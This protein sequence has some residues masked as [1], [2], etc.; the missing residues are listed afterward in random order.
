MYGNFSQI[1]QIINKPV[2]YLSYLQYRN[3][4]DHPI[5]F[6]AGYAKS[7]TTWLANMFSS[8]PG[9]HRV[10]PSHITNENHDINTKTFQE[11]RRQLAVICLHSPWTQENSHILEKNNQKYIVLYRDLRDTAVS[12]YFY[13]KNVNKKHSLHSTIKN[14][15]I[16]RGVEYYIEY[17]LQH[18]VNW[19]RS[20]RMNRHKD[21]ST[22]VR[23]EDLLNDTYIE[24]K[25]LLDFFS[26]NLPVAYIRKIVDKNSF[27]KMT[28]R[29]PGEEDNSSHLR[30]GIIGD[31]KN[32]LTKK[33]KEDFKRIAGDLL[34]E[35][36][37]EKDL[38]W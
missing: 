5:I 29:D 35:L 24:F 12:W 2:T 7:G 4:Y 6:I 26:I 23:Y 38:K 16:N 17:I 3:R 11:I 13:I 36:G 18:N 37:Y 10:F 34:I 31:W 14:L 19:I 22:E 28:K 1:K 20:W 15:P 27:K 33:N 30:K 8:V 25:R 9:F 32:V 21:L